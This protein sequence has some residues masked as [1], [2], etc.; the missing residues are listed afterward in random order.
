MGRV[1]VRMVRKCVEEVDEHNKVTHSSSLCLQKWYATMHVSSR[2]KQ[3]S[4]E[5]NVDLP[6]PASPYSTK[7]R[8]CPS[9][10]QYSPPN[11]LEAEDAAKNS[12]QQQNQGAV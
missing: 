3:H 9:L 6:T 11:H 1:A 7:A 2:S 5:V 4:L 10:V 8:L 12:E